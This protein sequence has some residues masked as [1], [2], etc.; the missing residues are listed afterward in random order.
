M[1]TSKPGMRNI[2]LYPELCCKVGADGP[3][4][5]NAAPKKDV[6]LCFVLPKK[7]CTCT[8]MLKKKEELKRRRLYLYLS[9]MLKKEEKAEKL[10]PKVEHVPVRHAEKGGKAGMLKPKLAKESCTCMLSWSR[11]S[12]NAVIKRNMYMYI[13]LKRE[14]NEEL[15]QEINEV[16]NRVAN[17]KYWK[18]DFC[19]NAVDVTVEVYCM[20]HVELN[21]NLGMTATKEIKIWLGNL[22]IGMQNWEE[23]NE[24]S[25]FR[26]A[27]ES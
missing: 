10:K 26:V 3:L 17:R 21:G 7:K 15:L 2:T 20:I 6:Y 25:D 4:D 19:L 8:S 12:R 24:E 16:F 11:K 22:T 18:E 14:K 27:N 9:A 23:C 1:N 5:W 13:V